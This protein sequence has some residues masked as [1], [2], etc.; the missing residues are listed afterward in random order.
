[1]SEATRDAKKEFVASYMHGHDEWSLH[2]FAA[3]LADAERKVTSIKR[4]LSL[5]GEVV[6]AVRMPWLGIN[7]QLIAERFRL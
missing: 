3:D 4:T 5:D 6:V 7:W 2:F 1:M